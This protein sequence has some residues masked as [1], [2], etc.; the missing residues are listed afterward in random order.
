MVILIFDL[1]STGHHIEYLNHLWCGASK[2]KE[3]E[4]VFAV[5]ETVQEVIN[6]NLEWPNSDNIKICPISNYEISRI[7]GGSKIL[8]SWRQSKK[9]VEIA[10]SVRADQIILIT[11]LSVIPF[12]PFMLP[13]TIKLSGII[14]QIF[15]YNKNKRGSLIYNILRYR[16]LAKNKHI[17][18]VFILNDSISAQKLNQRFNSEKFKNLPDPAPIMPNVKLQNLRNKLGIENNRIIFLHF[19]A[20]DGRKGTLD[21]LKAISL[22]NKNNNYCFVFA[23]KINQSI[24]EEFYRLYKELKHNGIKIFVKD[25]FCSY[26]MLHNFCHT[27]DC[28]LIPYH[29]TNLSSGVIGYASLHKTPVI[30][31]SQGLIGQLIKENR[32]GSTIDEIT[33]KNIYYAITH[34]RPY[35]INSDY[36]QKN[37]IKSFIETILD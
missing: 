4:Y 3:N 7:R 1:L 13:S 10:K 32:I 27:A 14:Y 23:G 36:A 9:I 6:S 35:S 16:L 11:L 33:P 24:K 25:E 37:S 12:L 15:L 5:S 17:K 19:G 8:K 34:F 18:K 30:G 2:R 29:F 26:E 28:I 31:P 22:L 20:M 21:I